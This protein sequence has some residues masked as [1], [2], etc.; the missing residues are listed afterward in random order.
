MT[1]EAPKTPSG[2]SLGIG[3]E[4][5]RLADEAES[6]GREIAAESERRAAEARAE[7][8]EATAAVH[9]MFAQGERTA[10]EQAGSEIRAHGNGDNMSPEPPAP[11]P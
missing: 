6:R 1:H 9:D 8:H 7:G 11:T 4:F 10:A 5:M 2:H 3:R